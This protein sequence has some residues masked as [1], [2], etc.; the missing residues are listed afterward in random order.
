MKQVVT[1]KE[2]YFVNKWI[3]NHPNARII[4][5][6]YR[7]VFNNYEHCIEDLFMIVFEDESDKEN[8]KCE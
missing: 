3:K 2:E 7:P 8:N 5:I 4:D 1:C 6:Q